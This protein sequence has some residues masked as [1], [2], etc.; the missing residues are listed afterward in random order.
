M[1]RDELSWRWDNIWVGLFLVVLAIV[2][3]W[4]FK[5]LL[6]I[7]TFFHRT[8]PIFKFTYSL[9]ILLA[10]LLLGLF[11][12]IGGLLRPYKNYKEEKPPEKDADPKDLMKE[13][14]LSQGMHNYY[15]RLTWQI[16]TIFL[17]GGVAGLGYA[18]GTERSEIILFATLVFTI[19]IGS[20]Y[21][22]SGRNGKLAL[23]HLARCREIEGKLGLRQHI[24]AGFASK[25]EGVMIQGKPYRAPL[26]SGWQIVKVLSLSLII[27]AWMITLYFLWK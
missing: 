1:N 13:Y 9:L 10:I 23:V 14:A 24:D 12:I 20:F 25:P 6:A 3:F 5:D 19:L 4:L 26:P 22:F 21:L 18:I 7:E 15:G 2:G 11:N 16:G 27:L 8:L 17:G